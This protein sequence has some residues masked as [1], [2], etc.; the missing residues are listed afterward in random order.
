M[1]LDLKASYEFLASSLIQMCFY[2]VF[3]LARLQQDGCCPNDH[4]DTRRISGHFLPFHVTSSVPGHRGEA[5]VS[6][7]Y[8]KHLH[9]YRHSFPHSDMA[10]QLHRGKAAG[11]PQEMV[12]PPQLLPVLYRWLPGKS[13]V[14]TLHQSLEYHCCSFG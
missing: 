1:H 11:G 4:A 5:L 14:S 6:C 10:L 13:A 12:R 7:R 8:H 9:G 3:I 2:M